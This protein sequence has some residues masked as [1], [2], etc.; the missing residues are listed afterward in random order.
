MSMGTIPS[1]RHRK[2]G[3]CPFDSVSKL[4]KA[5]TS[6][7]SEVGSGGFVEI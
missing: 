3:H 1:G 7:I 4:A 5:L 6:H 2:V